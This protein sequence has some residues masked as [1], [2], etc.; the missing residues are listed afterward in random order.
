MVR[1]SDEQRE[2]IREHYPCIAAFSSGVEML[3]SVL[4]DLANTLRERRQI[5]EEECFID[6][7]F[8]AAKGGRA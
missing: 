5:A 1:L 2:R 6:A 3:R 7:M 8:S 4:T